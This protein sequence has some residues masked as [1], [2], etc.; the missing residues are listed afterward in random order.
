MDH[1]ESLETA[2]ATIVQQWWR[3]PEI[4]LSCPFTYWIVIFPI[5][6][7]LVGGDGSCGVFVF[8]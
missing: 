4:R 2:D 6:V 7:F 5:T 1:A 8:L 3:K